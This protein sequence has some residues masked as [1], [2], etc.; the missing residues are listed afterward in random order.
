MTSNE[1][2]RTILQTQLY[3]EER[4]IEQLRRQKRELTTY[5]EEALKFIRYKDLEQEFNEWLEMTSNP[6]S[7]Q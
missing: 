2:D 7:S 4:R 3:L 6:C 1:P 5:V